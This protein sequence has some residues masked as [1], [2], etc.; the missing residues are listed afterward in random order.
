M[1]YLGGAGQLWGKSWLYS[2]INNAN[3][4]AQLAAMPGTGTASVN[5]DSVRITVYWRPAPAKVPKRYYYQIWD[6][7]GQYVGLLPAVVSEFNYG[8]DINSAGTNLNT[9]VGIS[10]D[11]SM[12]STN[13]LT[14]ESGNILTDES[15]NILYNEGVAPVITLG[16]SGLIRLLRTATRYR[17]P[18][19]ATTGQPASG[20]R[21]RNGALGS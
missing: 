10:P 13:A 20:I 21:W 18:R 5:V 16:L 2:D 9:E 8:Y 7:A 3:F 11:T 15:S 6:S 4:G 14:D 12:L 19:R 1:A 17:L